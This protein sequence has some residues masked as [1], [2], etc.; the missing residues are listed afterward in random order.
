VVLAQDSRVVQGTRFYLDAGYKN[1][2]LLGAGLAAVGLLSVAL[3][4]KLKR[5]EDVTAGEALSHS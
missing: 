4:P 3:I 1:A 2:M 5:T